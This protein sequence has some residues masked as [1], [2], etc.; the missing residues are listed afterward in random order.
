[1]PSKAAH[2]SYRCRGQWEQ[3]NQVSTSSERREQSHLGHWLSKF[4]RYGAL[5]SL[6]NNMDFDS[7]WRKNIYLCA[8]YYFLCVFSIHTRF[9]YTQAEIKIEITVSSN[10]IFL[11]NLEQATFWQQATLAWLIE[12]KCSLSA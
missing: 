10:L 1:M 2:S 9:R 7:R 5:R 3:R 11:E 4:S 8:G 6:K 12:H